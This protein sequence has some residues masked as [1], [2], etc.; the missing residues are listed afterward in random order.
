MS[1]ELLQPGLLDSPYCWL[2]RDGN[3]KIGVHIHDGWCMQL[4]DREVFFFA[5]PGS[6]IHLEPLLD[7]EH[8]LF[9]SFLRNSAFDNKAFSHKILDFPKL[10]LIRLV[11]NT[12]F[13]DYWPVRALAWLTA[14]KELIPELFADL[15][16]FSKNKAMG[17]SAR[18]LAKRLMRWGR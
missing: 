10:Q 6:C 7:L 4:D 14:D 1:I 13:S 2:I 17:Q 3:A 9:F 18:Q 15:D 16:K 5:Q 8:E 12:T 11:L